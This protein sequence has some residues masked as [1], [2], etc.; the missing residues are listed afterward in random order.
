MSTFFIRFTSLFLLNYC[1]NSFTKI[2]IIVAQHDFNNILLIDK[3]E[4]CRVPKAKSGLVILNHILALKT[5]RK[6][7]LHS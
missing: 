7:F 6:L 1:R 2:T 4:T 5:K 3:R